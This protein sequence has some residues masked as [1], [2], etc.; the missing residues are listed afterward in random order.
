MSYTVIVNPDPVRWD[1]FVS[2]HPDAHLLQ[3]SGWAQLKSAFGWSGQIIA[4]A[5][6]TGTLVAGAS[7]LFRPLPL[8]LGQMAYIPAG[9]LFSTPSADAALW[10]AVHDAAQRRRAAFLKVE[11]C[12]WYRSRPDLPARLARAG[13]RPSPHTVQPPRTIVIDIA[14]SEDDILRRMNQSTR[15]KARLGPKKE[16]SVREGIA[17]DLDSF[18][19]LMAI[20]GARD[21]FGVHE[22]AYYRMA[23]DLFAPAGRCA[24]IM[25]SYA[26]R[27]LAGVMAFHCGENAY[28]L[29]GASS[30]EE[31][32]R[33]APYIAQWE[34]IR[35][36]KRQGAIRY[37]LWGVPDADESTLEADFEARRDGLWGVYGA[38]RG[39]GG[40]L[41]RSAG[42]WDKPYNPLL[43]AAYRW[44]VGRRRAPAGSLPRDGQ[45]S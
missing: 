29:Y 25:A 31:R 1:A 28:Y 27:D 44:Y 35:W 18:T 20:T 32:N 42:A 38:K 10:R 8:R 16:V 33:M 6:G 40:Q 9:P 2:A 34:A 7:I 39:F 19:G 17:A 3:L 14:P 37:D 36:A 21:G 43:Y 5:D 26:G 22:P 45:Q 23:Y 13:C 12:D 24:L 15:Y 4:I 41:V 11:P 30:N